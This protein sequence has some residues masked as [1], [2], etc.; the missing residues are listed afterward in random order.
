M[1]YTSVGINNVCVKNQF[2]DNVYKEYL[3]ATLDRL[4]WDDVKCFLKV[5]KLKEHIN[6]AGLFSMKTLT[7]TF[8]LILR[9]VQDYQCLPISLVFSL[10]PF[11]LKM[12]TLPTFVPLRFLYLSGAHI[13][14][15]S[16]PFTLFFCNYLFIPVS[17]THLDVYKRQV[18]NKHMH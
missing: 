11:L 14:W 5:R 18:P 9:V 16:W 7:I 15:C 12:V 1:N 17:Y 3:V 2:I 10:S 4:R 8:P 13:L 6:A